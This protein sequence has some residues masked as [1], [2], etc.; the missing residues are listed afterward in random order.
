MANVI[1]AV[2]LLGII[3]AAIAKVIIEKKRGNKC[4]G[5]PHG[6]KSSCHCDTT[7]GITLKK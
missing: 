1:V 3:S 7:D 4:I 5:C 6:G 2:I